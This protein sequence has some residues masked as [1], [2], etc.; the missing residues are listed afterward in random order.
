MPTDALIT[1]DQRIRKHGFG[2]VIFGAEQQQGPHGI[3]TVPVV[4][5]DRDDISVLIQRLIVEHEFNHKRDMLELSYE[6][7]RLTLARITF[8]A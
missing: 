3:I 4:G 7:G 5:A 2:K 1:L 8:A 6:H